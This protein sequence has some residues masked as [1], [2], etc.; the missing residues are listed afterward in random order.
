MTGAYHQ[1]LPL[2]F[3]L[4]KTVEIKKIRIG[5]NTISIDTSESVKQSTIEYSRAQTNIINVI[6]FLAFNI[7]LWLKL[8]DP[9]ST[10]RC[11]Y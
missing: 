2:L 9:W 4:N 11:A 1:E 5:F 7:F 8:K 10:K 3:K 6:S